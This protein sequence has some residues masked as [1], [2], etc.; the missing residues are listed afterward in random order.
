[1]DHIF[2]LNSLIQT[3]LLKNQKLYSCFIDLSQ[4]FDSADHNRLWKVLLGAR[5]SSRL[6]SVLKFIYEN[7]YARVN[8]SYGLT[9]KI[10]TMKGVLQVIVIVAPSAETLQMKLITAANFLKERGLLVN[11]GKTKFVIFR[12]KGLL[13]KNETFNWNSSPF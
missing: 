9:E 1:L 6:V 11:L 13:K 3:Q 5:V 8:T 4:A 2:V 12:R 10:K 7:A